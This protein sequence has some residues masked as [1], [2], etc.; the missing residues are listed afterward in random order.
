MH[1]FSF[2]TT[3][4]SVCYSGHL[5]QVPQH[6]FHVNATFRDARR[7]VSSLKLNAK[8][9]LKAFGAQDVQDVPKN[10]DTYVHMY[11]SAIVPSS[12]FGVCDIALSHYTTL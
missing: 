11:M 6:N 8:R 10:A 4:N 12:T 3:G 9:S 1:T 7:V 5:L 2:Q